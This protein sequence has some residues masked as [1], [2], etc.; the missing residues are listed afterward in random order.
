MSCENCK[1]SIKEISKDEKNNE[2]EHGH[3]HS[4]GHIHK[5]KTKINIVLYII[6]C[7]SLV[8]GFIPILENIKPAI[9]MLSILFAGYD[10]IL[11]GI[12]NIFKLN[13]E[14]DTLM[15]IAVISSFLL[16]EFPESCL[17]VILFK[18]GQFLE[19]FAVNKSNSNIKE[20][21]KIKSETANLITDVE[22]KV[23][24]VE[25]I[26]I[27]NKILIKPGEKIPVDCIVLSGNSEIDTSMI[28]GESMPEMAEKDIELLSGSINLTGALECEVIRNYKESAASQI[29]DLVYEANNNKGK[30]EKFITKFS[31][32]YTPVIVILALL[33]T[34][35]PTFLGYDF[36]EWIMISLFFIVASCPCSL[37]ISVPLTFFSCIGAISKKGLIIKGTKHIENLSKAKV[38]AF[39]KTGTLTTG[40]MTINKIETLNDFKEK[41]IIEIIY[42]LE[43]LS[44]HPISTAITKYTKNIEKREVEKY[45]EIAGLGLYG[46][47]NEKEI[48]FGNKKLLE[49]YSIDTKEYIDGAIYL[50]VN[51]IIAGYIVLKEE[52]RKESKEVVKQLNEININKVVML[53]GDNK[54]SAQVIANETSIKEVYSELLPQNKLE[55]LN[56]LKENNKKVV[57]VG[58]GINDAPVISTADFGISMGTGAEIANNISDSILISNNIGSI[59][60]IIEI[61]RK[62]MR[63]I[64][65]NISFSL[66]IKAVVLLIGLIGI[67]PIW[68]AI[69]ADTG[70]TLLTVLNSVRV[71]KQKK[72]T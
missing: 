41:E 65:F 36:K 63:I 57:F 12:K 8:I 39:D 34:I 29:V 1:N 31:K 46:I 70:V 13:F 21:A 56:K 6:S 45:K 66:I 27:G 43:R 59:K 68:L 51:N 58:D 19:D 9:F 2:N 22:T 44:N 42:N 72:R 40:K 67:A 50:C 7:I 25:E 54:K 24:K 62:S 64:K 4:H 10:L 35:V 16:G 61:A 15:T 49:E 11:N 32:I 71:F 55:I 26:N 53:T 28:T 47:I 33:I 5:E 30:T 20:I 37:V 3:N 48:V 38:I 23:V 69:L 17:I 14:E 18:L 52:I 60:E